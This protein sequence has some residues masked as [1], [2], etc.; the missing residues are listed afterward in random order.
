MEE[1]KL[2]MLPPIECSERDATAS[3]AGFR[4]P[5]ILFRSRV[6]RYAEPVRYEREVRT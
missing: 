2:H 5:R 3:M 6:L 4:A 1:V